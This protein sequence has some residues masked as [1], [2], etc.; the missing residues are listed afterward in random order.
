MTKVTAHY[1]KELRY[2][3]T[4]NS[5]MKFL[6]VQLLGL[7]GKPHPALLNIHGTRQAHKARAHLKLLSGDFPSN[8]LIGNR[9]NM[10]PGCQLC[11]CPVESTQHIL[12]GCPATFDVRERLFPELLNLIAAI[13]PNNDLLL[14]NVT[15]H[16][17]TQFILDPTSVNLS[18]SCRV[19]PQNPR[20]SEIFSICRDW[21]F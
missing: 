21:C 15:E 5:C 14:N 16:T 2:R 19:S 11:P 6:N 18:N 13:D 20:L 7:S 9:L 10:N 4:K 12:T 1:E 8:E 3:A 17:L